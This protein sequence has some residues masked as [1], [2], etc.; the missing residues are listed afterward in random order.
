MAKLEDLCISLS[1]PKG[2]VDYDKYREKRPSSDDL[3]SAM[4]SFYTELGPDYLI[5]G[6]QTTHP[7]LLGYRQ[8]R[9]P[10]NDIDMVTTD[11]GLDSLNSRFGSMPEFFYSTVHGDVFLEYKGLPFGFVMDRIHE[12]SVP[13]ELWNTA[14]NIKV[15]S[16]TLTLASPEYTIMLKIMRA[17]QNGRFFGK[18]K[19]DITSLL[20]APMYNSSLRKVDAEKTLELIREHVTQDPKLI[21]KYLGEISS[22]Q[23]QLRKDERETFQ[24]VYGNFL[25]LL[26]P[27]F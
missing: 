23:D 7:K 25:N 27:Q 24:K 1:V 26:K 12:W 19:V 2:E 16:T 14:V 18:D 22:Y 6:G 5:I 8:M 17:H 11:S 20:L 21:G 13:D 15:D 10:S 3:L 9:R 4:H